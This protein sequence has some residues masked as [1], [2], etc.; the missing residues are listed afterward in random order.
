MYMYCL[1]VLLTYLIYFSEHL[2]MK[3]AAP[4]RKKLV[5]IGDGSCGKTCLLVVFSKNIFPDVYIPTVF[6]NYVADLNIDG[7][8]VSLLENRNLLTYDMALKRYV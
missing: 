8:M 2:T 1:I 5:V 4:I 6:E 3:Q 7:K